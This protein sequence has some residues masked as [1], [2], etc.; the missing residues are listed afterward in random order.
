VRGLRIDGS[1]GGDRRA[2]TGCGA[3]LVF[4]LAIVVLTQAFGAAP[5]SRPKV[6]TRQA[7]LVALEALPYEYDL[8]PVKVIPRGARAAIAGE[9]TGP[10]HTHLQFGVALG[11]R[12]HPVPVP[13]TGTTDVTFVAPANFTFTDD[14]LEEFAPHRFRPGPNIHSV[15]QERIA[16]E[17]ASRMESALCRAATG[18]GCGV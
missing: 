16:G 9:A 1:E 12:A 13:V 3:L 10:G 14:T 4:L 11:R 18:R 17:M 6:L 5:S 8:R 15:R 7:A 2:R